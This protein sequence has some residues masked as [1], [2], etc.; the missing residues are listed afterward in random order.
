MKRVSKEKIRKRNRK[1]WKTILV[2]GI[3]AAVLFAAIG[4]MIFGLLVAKQDVSLLEKPMPA[5]T[6]VYDQ[7]GKEALRISQRT[8]EAVSYGSLPQHLVDAVVAVEDKRFF[9]H[10]GTD[11]WG[12]GRAFLTNLTSGK[13]VQGASTITQQLAK[14]VFLSQER[15]WTRKWKELL[16]AQKIEKTYDKTQIMEKYL[17]QIY[18]GEG[19]WGIQKAADVYYGVSVDKLT[20]SES[21][22]L[23]GLIKAPSALSP[24]SHPEKALDR[25]NVVL[26]LLKEQGKIT[27]AAYEAATQEPLHLLSA[28]PSS[29]DAIKYPYYVDQV[30]REAAERYG[31]T[32]NE[33]LHGGLRIYTAL[34]P[35]MQQAAESVYAQASA[36]PDSAADQLIQSGAVLVDP[37]DGGIR[38]LVGGRGKQPFRGFNRAIQLKRQPGSTMK[39]ISVY[40]PAFE[41]GYTPE[42]KLLD[43]PVN[44]GGYQP[45]NAGGGYHGEVSIYDA[46]VNSYNIPAV[47]LLNEIGIDAGMESANRFGLKLTDADRTL[48]LA[49]GGLQE[50]VSPLEMAEA[51]GVFANDGTR[52]PAHSIMRIESADGVIVPAA[53]ELTA[54]K[55]TEPAVARTMT[56]VLE[57]VVSEG[58]GEL[59]ALADRPVAGKTGTTEMPGTGGKGIKDNWFVGYTPQ[60]VGAVWLGYDHTDGSHYLTTTSKAAAAVFQKLMTEALRGEPVLAFPAAKGSPKKK[61]DDPRAGGDQ[62]KHQAGQEQEEDKDKPKPPKEKKEKPNREE[63]DNP[64]HKQDD[65]KKDKPQPPAHKHGDP[66]EREKGKK[67]RE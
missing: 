43:E 55:T 13:T 24:Y 57:G 54:V 22:L 4:W 52:M 35:S 25:R 27:S 30:I 33:V 62:D 10:G 7:D 29:A 1:S 46:I 8:S 48:G 65:P 17:N 12:I 60:L 44:F 59:A 64:D 34:D 63:H 66:K 2:A 56:T 49:L 53:K 3:L 45:K 14:N 9:E 5:A 11:L 36:F 40:T 19:A 26:Q 58:T 23:A 6:M 21:A 20:L 37:R 41:R 32:E 42:D 67:G 61:K 15:T 28:K 18:F 50:G 51:F 39:P 31:L 38:A 16:L 47:R